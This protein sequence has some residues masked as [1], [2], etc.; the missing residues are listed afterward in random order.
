MTKEQ[1]RVRIEEIGIIPAVRL[2]SAA[3]ARFAAEAVYH[4][5]LRIIEITMTVPG[6]LDLIGELLRDFP[7][8]VAGGGIVHRNGLATGTLGPGAVD[9]ERYVGIHGSSC[10]SCMSQRASA[11]ILD[12]GAPAKKSYHREKSGRPGRPG[13]AADPD[14]AARNKI[15]PGS[16]PS[17]RQDFQS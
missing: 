13:R 15:M 10:M 14:S 4:A 3:D 17:A 12:P 11:G 16:A 2:G 6:A 9:V 1:V 8:F 5:G 7:D